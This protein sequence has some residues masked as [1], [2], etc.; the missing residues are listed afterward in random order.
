MCTNGYTG[1]SE[2]QQK[3]EQQQQQLYSHTNTET[4][5]HV[6]RNERKEQS[7]PYDR[8]KSGASSLALATRST[9][10]HGNAFLCLKNSIRSIIPD[11]AFAQSIVN[12]RPGT[13][14][15]TNERVNEERRRQ[16]QTGIASNNQK[17]NISASFAS[18]S[19]PCK[20]L[21]DIVIPGET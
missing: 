16:A 9:Q 1:G 18:S 19:F 11:E 3:Q 7:P 6:Q 17:V 15:R 14:E 10:L 4:H 5:T 20:L 8:K 21:F 12:E 13:S 2:R